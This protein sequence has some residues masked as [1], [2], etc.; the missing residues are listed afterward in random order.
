LVFDALRDQ[1]FKGPVLLTAG[2][3]AGLNTLETK[4]KQ[5]RAQ[6]CQ[7]AAPPLDFLG[8]P[9]RFLDR[10]APKALIVIETE[11]WPELFYQCQARSIPVLLLSARLSQRSHDRLARFKSFI[12]QTLA[13]PSLVA[14]ISQKDF[15][16]LTDLGL[17][18]KKA[19]VIGS[20][21][22]DALIA[23][24]QNALALSG[25]NPP[26]LGPEVFAQ[27]QKPLILAGS[28][29]PGEEE[30]I[31]SALTTLP[32]LGAALALAPRHLTRLSE[33]TAITQS[34]GLKPVF[35]S[36]TNVLRP[37]PGEVTLVDK[38]G[39]LADLY[40]ECDLAIIGG[41]F[42]EGAGH[43]PLEPAAVG[44]PLIFGPNM[45]SFKREAEELVTLGVATSSPKAFL[46]QAISDL[47][48]DPNRARALGR[49]GQKYLAGQKIVAPVLAKLALDFL[50][51][52]KGLGQV[53][54]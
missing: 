49:K 11:L 17:D 26:D 7:I 25:P 37:G 53:Q 21:K 15:D 4:T 32:N 43:N 5:S 20:P 8:A 6:N 18:P 50:A 29:H 48:A 13:I 51:K 42:F 35:L 52:P 9:G 44:K 14:T 24:A 40:R 31:L 36:E 1:G 45:S 23:K 41:S 38:M 27:S 19:S 54:K 28:T 10:V 46:N 22:F 39:L 30:L 33:V 12:G 3:P 16:L 47:L 2:T 34:F